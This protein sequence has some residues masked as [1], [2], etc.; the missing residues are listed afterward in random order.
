MS[1]NHHNQLKKLTTW[2]L[3]LSLDKYIN[4]KKY[5][6]KNL[7]RRPYKAQLEEQKSKTSSRRPSRRGKSRKTNTWHEKRQNEEKIKKISNSQ[8]KR[9]PPESIKLTLTLSM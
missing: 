5:K 9:L 7:N 8:T 1:M 2:F 3:N 4:N 6:V